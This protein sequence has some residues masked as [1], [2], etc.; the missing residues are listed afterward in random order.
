MTLSA[1]AIRTAFIDS[2]LDVAPEAD[3]QALR[4]DRPMRAQLDIDSFDFLRVLEALHART[5]ID[6]P[7]ADY[8]KLETFGGALAYLAKRET[9]R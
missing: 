7:E 5:G 6:V 3:L 4:A 9:D 1:E 2:I 8:P